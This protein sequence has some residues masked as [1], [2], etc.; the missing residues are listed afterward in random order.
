MQRTSDSLRVGRNLHMPWLGTRLESASNCCQDSA[1]EMSVER[2]ILPTRKGWAWRRI[3]M[4]QLKFDSH[5]ILMSDS[6]VLD[7]GL[8]KL[9]VMPL[10]DAVR[11]DHEDLR[12]PCILTSTSFVEYSH[13]LGRN[14][15]KFTATGRRLCPF[16]WGSNTR[17]TTLRSMSN[18]IS[19]QLTLHLSAWKLVH[20]R[21]HQWHGWI[22]HGLLT[23]HVLLRSLTICGYRSSWKE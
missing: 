12:R 15:V 11:W 6:C 5:L 2:I 20:D 7:C 22:T 21:P 23:L 17:Q 4:L 13:E 3:W 19:W 8:L 1:R 16:S 10:C 9:S 14:R 18:R